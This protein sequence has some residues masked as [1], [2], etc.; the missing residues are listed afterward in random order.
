MTAREQWGGDEWEEHC[1]LLLGAKYGENIQFVPARTGGDGGLEAYRLDC[2]TT[3]QC[4]APQD[5]LTVQAQTDA[6]K[7]KNPEGHPHAGQ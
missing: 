3:Y 7:R 1:C 6:Q 4:Y 2:G 5:A